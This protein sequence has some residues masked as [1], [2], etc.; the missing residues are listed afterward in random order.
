M[1]P[2]HVRNG[3][4]DVREASVRAP[5]PLQ[6]FYVTLQQYWDIV[7]VEWNGRK[8]RNGTTVRHMEVVKCLPSTSYY[9]RLAQ[10]NNQRMD[11]H[12]DEQTTSVIFLNQVVGILSIYSLSID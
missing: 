7:R 4:D 3:L 1:R 12:V 5:P 10:L 6:V 9:S 11:D 2:F 8:D